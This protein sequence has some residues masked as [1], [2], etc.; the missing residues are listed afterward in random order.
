MGWNSNGP[1]C[2]SRLLSCAHNIPC[3]G[4]LVGLCTPDELQDEMADDFSFDL[5]KG[6]SMTSNSGGAVFFAFFSRKRPEALE[7]VDA[8][9][10]R[11]SGEEAELGTLVGEH[12][13]HQARLHLSKSLSEDTEEELEAGGEEQE[14]KPRR[15]A[16]DQNV[17]TGT[18]PKQ[19]A[20]RG[21]GEDGDA[22][23]ASGPDLPSPTPLDDIHE[24]RAGEDDDDEAEELDEFLDD[25]EED[26][27]DDDDW[28]DDAERVCVLKFLPST[29]E[30]QAEYCANQIGMALNVPVPSIKIIRRDFVGWDTMASATYALKRSF[31]YMQATCRALED[32]LE[33]RQC[34]L[35]FEFVHGSKSLTFER[36]RPALA[37][38]TEAI[39]SARAQVLEAANASPRDGGDVGPADAEGGG[40]DPAGSGPAGSD[41]DHHAGT[42][43]S[44][45][46]CEI[47]GEVLVFDIAMRNSDRFPC[48]TL[49]WR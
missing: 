19:K 14:A 37:D 33:D 42:E 30:T 7:A 4:R 5:S 47:V 44:K 10:R 45:S 20:K 26:D 11:S 3:A 12:Q 2:L 16:G 38:P 29:M 36:I 48:Q 31:K 18:S 43:S 6:V 39:A 25:D 49:G 41:G 22:G 21:P 23:K 17:A 9:R 40:T 27:D 32:S 24:E 35:L 8:E 46:M 1:G 15:D 28:D 34:G 13:Q